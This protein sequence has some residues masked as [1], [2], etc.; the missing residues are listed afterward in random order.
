M[1]KSE[2]KIIVFPDYQKLKDSVEK[3]KIELS[4]LLLERDE[5]Q[6]VICKNIETAYFL[7]FGVLEHKA[8]EAECNALRLKRKVE[9]V[10]ARL[11]RQEKVDISHVEKILDEEFADYQKI[12]NEQIEK[13]KEALERSKL[14]ILSE[15]E[16]EELKSL[17]RKI[18]K[19]LHP[20]LNPGANEAEI[21]LFRKAVTAYKDGNLAEL[22]IIEFIVSKQKLP[23]QEDGAL[24]Q[25]SKEN[26]R[27]KK[28]ISNIHKNIAEIKDSFPYT[29]KDI[30]ENK[31]KEE[32]HRENLENIL[33]QYE[34]LIEIYEAK[35]ADMLGGN[36]S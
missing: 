25:L 21:E 16:T 15:N 33:K 26:E 20:D 22:R 30:V 35:L 4:M 27:L 5:L 36:D 9:L 1:D 34:E 23:E 3:M 17:Y 28:I 31:E 14:K 8:Y 19:L 12:L 32:S 18:V 7:K 10:Q 24:S 29:V 2:N 11:N 13:M 6:F